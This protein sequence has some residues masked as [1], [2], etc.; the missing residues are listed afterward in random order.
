MARPTTVPSPAATGSGGMREVDIAML[1]RCVEQGLRGPEVDPNP[2]VGCVVLDAAGALVGLGH[3]DG[4][5]SAHAEVVA[6]TEAGARAE[7]GTAY[8]SLEPCGHTGRTPP[9]TRALRESGVSR[10]VYARA[11]PDPRA[12]G[13]GQWLR[14]HGVLTEQVELAEA[15]DLVR[16]WAFAVTHGRPW[17]TWKVATTL[18]GR[19]AASDGSS[20]WV[21]G[22]QARADVHR[23]RSRCG[24]I[25][26]G[27]GTALAD[28]PGLTARRP[29]GTLYA[30]QPLRVVVGA[31]D[32][33]A[34]ARVEPAL[35]L[36]SGEV[37]EVT[38]ALHSR[39]VRRVLLEG[40]PTLAAAFWRAGSVDE[41]IAYVAPALLGSGAPAVADLGIE[42]I[43]D[44][45]RMDIVDVTRVG[46]DV[47][48][49]GHPH[50]DEHRDRD[51]DNGKA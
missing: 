9:C 43:A 33:P 13:G 28:D 27:T 38:E 44:I 49:T 2:R 24:A 39:G 15:D 19:V 18:D 4:A 32:L 26:V 35:R 40:G 29:D 41:V 6:L 50:R 34:G 1:S 20:A 3:H 48:I 11:D 8:V 16:H 7:G 51:R 10:V 5:G 42:T 12:A 30:D 31:R 14:R 23:L 37:G 17:V 22:E 45:A 36:R 46:A 25:V 47:R 21:T